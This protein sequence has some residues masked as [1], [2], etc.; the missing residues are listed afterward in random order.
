MRRDPELAAVWNLAAAKGQDADAQA[1]LGYQYA[2]GLGVNRDLAAA[3]KWFAAAAAQDHAAGQLG[4]GMLYAG[5]YGDTHTHQ[6]ALTWLEKAAAHGN[7]TAKLCLAMLLVYGHGATRDET[8]GRSLLEE[9]A[10]AGQPAAMFHLGELHRRG[11]GATSTSQ[12]RKPGCVAPPREATSRLCCRWPYCLLSGPNRNPNS[13]AALCRQAAELGDGEAQ[14]QLAQFY[15]AGTGVPADP[16][17]AAR[18][19]SKAAEQGVSAA[20]ERLGALYA[21]GLECRKTSRQRPTGFNVRS[22]RAMS[23]PSIT[24]VLCKW[25]ALVYRAIQLPRAGSI[26]RPRSSEA[27]RPACS[28]ESFMPWART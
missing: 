19:M 16:M 14:Y 8:R 24:S 25:A 28:S 12:K 1:R 22:C 23:M 15:L 18:W 5:S 26:E 21:E 3:E 17:E 11:Q 13:A 4:L 27:A 9:A 10:N 6:Q 20:F 2:S 7:A